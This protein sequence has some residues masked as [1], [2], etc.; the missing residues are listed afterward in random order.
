MVQGLSSPYGAVVDTTGDVFIADAGNNRILEVPSTDLTCA[1]QREI[2][3]LWVWG[4][5]APT[6]IAIDQNGD[7]YV[8]DFGNA[9]A[10]E[11]Q[12]KAVNLGSNNVGSTSGHSRAELH[13]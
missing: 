8:A 10:L 9:R 3:S 7:F 4:L 1:T 13:V 12:L 5:N 2:A 6:G 11:L